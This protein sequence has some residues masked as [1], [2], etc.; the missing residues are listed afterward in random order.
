MEVFVGY[1]LNTRVEIV[2]GIF[3]RKAKY[4]KAIQELENELYYTGE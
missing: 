4:L 1:R 2:N 3:G